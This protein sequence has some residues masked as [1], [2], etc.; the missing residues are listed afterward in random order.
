MPF[1]STLAGTPPGVNVT[2][3]VGLPLISTRRPPT[4]NEPMSRSA[5]GSAACAAAV[6]IKT[7]AAA[8]STSRDMKVSLCFPTKSVSCIPR[9]FP[10]GDAAEHAADGHAHPGGVT[11]AEHVAGHDLAGSEHVGG[12]L[13]VL[14]QHPRLFVHAGAEIGEGDAGAHRI[15]IKGRRLDPPRPVGFRRR[16]TFGAAIVENCGIEGAGTNRG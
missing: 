13:A 5:I 11:L 15:G 4:W 7:A 6:I 1:G 10:A 16:Q 8:A 12:R 2:S 14:H 3:L 9:R